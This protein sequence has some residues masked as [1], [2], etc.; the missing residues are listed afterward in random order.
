M[1]NKNEMIF[2]SLTRGLMFYAVVNNMHRTSVRKALVNC[3]NHSPS[4]VVASQFEARDDVHGLQFL[5]EQ[6]AGIWNS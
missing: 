1:F 5:E 4:L 3:R 2:Q 6:F